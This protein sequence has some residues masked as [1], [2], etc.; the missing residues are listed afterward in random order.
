M[1]ME[2]SDKEFAGALHHAHAELLR[3][4]RQLEEAVHS[5]SSE[6]PT[7]LGARLEKVRAHLADHFR[8]EEQDGYMAPILKEEP[9][10]APLVQELL[11]EHGQ[12]AQTVDALLQEVRAARSLQDAM[13]ESVRAWVKRVRQHES[14]E[15]SLVQ[16]V[17]NSSEATGD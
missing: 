1:T 14:R 5:G 8:F 4:L 10:F 2:T 16:E 9:R 17:Y 3:D 6:G 12:L 13:R 15:N 11:D 7:E